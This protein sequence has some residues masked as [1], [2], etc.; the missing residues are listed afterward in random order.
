MNE[1]E[2][3]AYEHALFNVENNVQ[4]TSSLAWKKL[5]EYVDIVVAK[6]SD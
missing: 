6:G 4:D 5:C 2:E 1:Q 3:N